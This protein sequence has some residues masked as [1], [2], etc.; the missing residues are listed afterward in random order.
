MKKILPAL[1]VF[2]VSFVGLQAQNRLLSLNHE[3]ISGAIPAQ[4][5]AV[6]PTAEE[7]APQVIV[8]EYKYIFGVNGRALAIFQVPP[9]SM[10]YDKRGIL[11]RRYIPTI[12]LRIPCELLQRVQ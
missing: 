6:K 8:Q 4:E 10:Q 2:L 11:Y 12:W 3:L 9:T 1:L 5:S 7:N